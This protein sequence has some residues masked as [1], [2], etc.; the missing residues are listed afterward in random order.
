[1][2]L[3]VAYFWCDFLAKAKIIG[4]QMTVK[5]ILFSGK[6]AGEGKVGKSSDIIFFHRSS[7]RVPPADANTPFIFIAVVAHGDKSGL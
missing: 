4:C 6:I 5:I 1:M 3:E 7:E 2:F